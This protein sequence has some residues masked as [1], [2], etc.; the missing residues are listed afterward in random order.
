MYAAEERIDPVDDEAGVGGFALEG[1]LC[2]H[3]DVAA[4]RLEKA[5]EAA[6]EGVQARNR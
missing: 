4:A 5:A 3:P 6:L 2:H 1:L